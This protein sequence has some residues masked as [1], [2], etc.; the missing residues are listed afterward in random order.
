MQ[1]IKRTLTYVLAGL[2]A[3][4]LFGGIVHMVLVLANVSKP[5]AT[6]VY[7]LTPRRIW[8]LTVI[9]LALVSLVVGWRIFRRAAGDVNI[10]KG[11]RQAIVAIVLGLLAAINGGLNLAT[12][13][14][15]P[16][17]GNGVVGSA[18]ALVLGLTGVVLGA[19]AMRRF[20]RRDLKR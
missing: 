9:F 19:L 11:K 18:Q 2:P 13:N 6:T 15:G 14:G 12:A 4:A 7:G 1:N 16:G 3:V 8:A 20:K 17:T 10:L 5:A